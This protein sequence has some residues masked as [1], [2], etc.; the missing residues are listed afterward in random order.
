MT[1]SSSTCNGAP[2]RIIGMETTYLGSERRYGGH[3]ARV[4]IT[5]IFR[6]DTDEESDDRHVTDNAQLALLG[7]VQPGDG[8]EVHV[9]NDREGRWGFV[10]EEIEDAF[11]LE[12]FQ[13]AGKPT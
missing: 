4:L 5:A 6:Y 7:S 9:W 11:E 2:P 13:C 10:G 3:G 1:K 12:L 8:A